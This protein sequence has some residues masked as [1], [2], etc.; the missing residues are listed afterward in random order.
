MSVESYIKKIDPN[1]TMLMFNAQSIEEADTL[2]FGESHDSQICRAL[3]SKLVSSIAQYS[4][5]KI[6]V[7]SSPAEGKLSYLESF[8]KKVLCIEGLENVSLSGWDYTKTPE[9]IQ[10]NQE[11]VQAEMARRALKFEED[12]INNEIASVK[13]LIE[14][15]MGPA[16]SNS[17]IEEEKKYWENI[18]NFNDSDREYILQNMNEL[19]QL[20]NQMVELDKQIEKAEEKC[21]ICMNHLQ[22]VIDRDFPLRTTAMMTTL[23]KLRKLRKNDEFRGKAVFQAGEHHLQTSES[24]RNKP[25]YDLTRLYNEL[26]KHRAIILIPNSRY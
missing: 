26:R 11:A 16:P 3:L 8:Y 25:E 2:L 9:C 1:Y 22:E 20:T 18:V 19:A 14:S 15:K 7:E 6:F 24:N 10:A 12:R 21:S 13:C 17:S 4:F 5:V 23:K